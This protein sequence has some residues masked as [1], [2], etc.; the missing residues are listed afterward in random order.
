MLHLIWENLKDPSICIVDDPDNP[1]HTKTATLT[2]TIGILMMH[3]GTGE[4]TEKNADEFY[5]RAHL[6]EACFDG[7]LMRNHKGEV[8]GISPADV[9]AHIGLKSNVSTYTETQFYS[10]LRKNV[11]RELRQHYRY[12]VKSQCDT[13]STA[14]VS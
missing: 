6:I 10:H 2:F 4:I 1:G 9:Y 3:T 14:P 12:Y 11:V 7:G 5:V 13:G 8:V